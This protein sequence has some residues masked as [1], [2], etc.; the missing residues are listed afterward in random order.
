MATLFEIVAPELY[1]FG[2]ISSKIVSDAAG[3]KNIKHMLL[4]FK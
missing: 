1:V 4:T 3:E 2:K